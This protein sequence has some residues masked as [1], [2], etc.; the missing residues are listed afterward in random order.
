MSPKPDETG[1]TNAALTHDRAL[2]GVAGREAVSVAAIHCSSELISSHIAWSHWK[3]YHR[4]FSLRWAAGILRCHTRVNNQT[5]LGNKTVCRWVGDEHR[6]N[7]T[8]CSSCSYLY[9]SQHLACCLFR[10]GQWPYHGHD[11]LREAGFSYLHA[12]GAHAHWYATLTLSSCRDAS[13]YA[14]RWSEAER[15]VSVRWKPVHG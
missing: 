6:V 13:N 14:G 3:K 12:L 9:V 8:L 1:R 15:G 4:L 5:R 11:L 7:W 10:E 2:I